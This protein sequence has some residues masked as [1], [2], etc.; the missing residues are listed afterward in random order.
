MVDYLQCECGPSKLL[1]VL[2]SC[3]MK[4]IIIKQRKVTTTQ[5]NLCFHYHP[6]HVVQLSSTQSDV[7]LCMHEDE[8][9]LSCSF[10]FSYQLF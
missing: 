8:G 10:V 7:Y 1:K 5:L 9:V 2:L 6:Y 4:I 3:Q